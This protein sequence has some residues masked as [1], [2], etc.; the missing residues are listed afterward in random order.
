MKTRILIYKLDGDDNLYHILVD[1]MG[2]IHLA[3]RHI[4]K[5]ETPVTWWQL[6]NTQT[7]EIIASQTVPQLQK[8]GVTKLATLLL[9]VKANAMQRLA[10]VLSQ[11]Q[12][13]KDYN[14]HLSLL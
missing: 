2:S 5:Q 6:I 11:V 7:G 10:S 4:A 12:D 9:A 14:Q 1:H 8:E 13:K 3:Q